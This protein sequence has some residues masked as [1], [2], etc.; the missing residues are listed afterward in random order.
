MSAAIKRRKPGGGRKPQGKFKGNYAVLNLRVTREVRASLKRAAKKNGESL[1]QEAQ[2]RL[3]Q[4]FE[5]DR[6]A[7]KARPNHIRAL[8]TT[9]MLAAARIEHQ[10]GKRW[11]D[12]ADTTKHLQDAVEFLI[13]HFGAKSDTPLADPAKQ[14]TDQ[15]VTPSGIPWNEAI[16]WREAGQVIAAI[17]MWRG[18]DLDETINLINPKD[19]N[20]PTEWSVADNLARDLNRKLDTDVLPVGFRPSA[21]RRR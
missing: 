18:M 14:R 2:K 8:G 20:A 4:S 19:D 9:I 11:L 6:K 21:R 5:D 15:P 13:R 17:D 7:R 12:D 3:D 1:S 10:T 16:G